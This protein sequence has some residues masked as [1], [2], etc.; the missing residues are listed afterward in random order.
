M[1]CDISAATGD[2]DD[3]CFAREIVNGLLDPEL[4]LCHLLFLFRNFVFNRLNGIAFSN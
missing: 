3:M 4:E 2:L 1:R